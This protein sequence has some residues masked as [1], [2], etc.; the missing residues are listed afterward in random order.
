M[1]HL[2]SLAGLLLAGAAPRQESPD[3]ATEYARR[4]RPLMAKSCLECHSTKLKKGELDL[5]R[6]LT[7]DAVRKDLRPWPHLLEQLETGEMPPKKGPPL[8]AEDR[9][10]LVAWTRAMLDAEARA[11]AGDPGR[12]LVRRLGNAEYDNTV[13][14]L[15]GVDLAPSR[16]F[17]VD[18]VAGEGFANVGDAL[19]MSPALLGKYLNAAK[20]IGGHLVLLP[21]G[22]RFS[23]SKTRRDWTD[24]SV[25]ALRAFYK[26]HSADG[27]LPLRPHLLASIRHRAALLE[28]KSDPDAVAA[29]EKIN[30]KYFRALWAALTDATPSFPLDLLRARWRGAAEK[31]VDGLVADVAAWQ[32]S[33]WKFHKVGSYGMGKELRAEANDPSFVPSQTVR[34]ELKPAPG[35]DEVVVHLAALDLPA[36]DGP[37]TWLRPRFEGGKGAPLLL[38]DYAAYGPKYE[39]DLK[40]AFAET[41]KYLEA[42]RDPARA[43]GLDAE[44]LKRWTGLLG[45]QPLAEPGAP[46]TLSPAVPLDL[47]DTPA[48]G[49]AKTPAIQGWRSKAGDLP[50]VLSNASDKEERIPGRAS[51]H[52]IVV[53]PLPDRFVAIAWDSPVDGR[54]RLE[55]VFSHAHGGCGNGVAYWVDFRRGDRAAHLSQGIVSIGGDAA[56]PAR[57]VTVAKGDALVVAIDARDGSHV[58]DL[59]EVNVTVRETA[60]E[61]R[62]WNLAS[63]VADTILKSNPHGAWR[64]VHGPTRKDGAAAGGGIPAGSLLGQWRTA[65]DEALA[66]KVQALLNGPRPRDEKHPDRAVYDALVTV[67]GPLFRDFDFARLPKLAGRFG[68]EAGDL[69]ARTAE[70]RLPAALFR[71]R[72]FVVEGTVDGPARAVQFSA[73]L[74][75]LPPTRP[76]DGKS[77]C[78]ATGGASKRLVAG[79]DDFRRLFPNFICFPQVIP[80]DEVVCLKLFHR[81]DEPL[82]RLFLDDAAARRLDRLWAE[83]RYISQWPTTE[84]KNLPLFIG[85]VTQDGTKEA[86]A[87]FE[88]LRE[89]FR[90]RAEAFEKEVEATYSGHVDALLRFAA[91]AYRRPLAPG[92]AEGIRGLYAKLRGKEL[93]HEEAVRGALVRILA[94]PAFLFRLEET[95]PGAESRPVSGPELATRLS[96][97]LWASMPDAGLTALADRLQDPAVL[98]A[99][100]DR[101][102]RDPKARGLAEEF[103]LRWLHVRDLRESKEKNE[104]LFPTFDAPLRAALYEEAVRFFQ[105]LFREGRPVDEILTADYAFLNEA[106]AKHYGIPGVKGPEWRRVDGV[107]AHGRGG[108]IALGSVLAKESGASRTSPV[109]RGNWLVE[110]MLGEK[111]P[112]PPANVPQLPEQE[113]GDDLTV[114]AMTARHTR[115]PECATCHVRIDPFGFALEAYDAIGRRRDK[116]AGGRPIDAR[117][118]LRDGTE[119]EGLEGLRAYLLGRKKEFRKTFLRKLL[120]YALGRSVTLSDQA[121]LD[122]IAGDL[123][124]GEGRLSDVVRAIVLSRPFREHRG[125]EATKSE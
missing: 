49:A 25:A 1:R 28:G 106:L 75:A 107:R 4:I 80:T 14:D 47:L 81:D 20:E 72:A 15:T 58:C 33:L 31:D 70:I 87:F 94:S 7:L 3:L 27:Q 30:A 95:P 90:K 119:F 66:R 34:V 12:V 112:K 16:D 43:G 39:V 69:T 42:A 36:S 6:F 122:G 89:P 8:A 84:H 97:F 48:P 108:V 109:L 37:V 24:E 103:A 111:L 57:E 5:E 18:G 23:P 121:L 56:A 32:K 68:L 79:F 38:R 74:S 105:H 29:R 55:A 73:T 125:L 102:V 64:F 11:R 51:P 9:K 41:A 52:R 116:D 67:D 123:E 110:T 54:V 60:G 82:V 44:W 86:L 85:F 100:V 92:E 114:R 53:H 120:G 62:T 77:P 59:T 83:Q 99:Q 50:V 93:S 63:D 98:A 76:W 21:D 46:G 96:Y 78:V 65:P 10:A 19:V 104:K 22:F 91:R 40:A 88:G 117:A 17:P 26:E 71:D 101:M 45:L 61:K 124:K 113:G 118:T 115:V 13:R 35:Q 2:L